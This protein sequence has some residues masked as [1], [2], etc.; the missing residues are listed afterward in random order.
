MPLKVEKL[1]DKVHENLLKVKKQ[2]DLSV[3]RVRK[4]AGLTQ[5]EFGERIGMSQGGVYSIEKNITNLT[6][7]TSAKIEEEF[8]VGADW[9][10][11]GDEEKKDFPVSKKLIDWLWSNPDERESLWR[12]MKHPEK[13]LRENKI[14][15]QENDAQEIDLLKMYRKLSEEKKKCLLDIAKFFN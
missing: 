7:Y 5:T 13:S 6:P 12:K 4:D 3:R 9:L 10:M 8:D 1:S 15:L 14:S 11:Y 2:L